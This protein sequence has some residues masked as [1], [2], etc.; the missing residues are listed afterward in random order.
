MK[1][2]SISITKAQL[3]SFSVSLNK[4]QPE[5]SATIGLFTDGGKKISDYTIRTNDWEESSTF[6]L[7][8]ELL[9]LIGDTMRIL[10]GVVVRHCRDGQLGL[11]APA[12]DDIALTEKPSEEIEDAPIDL[13]DI[14][15]GIKKATA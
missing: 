1:K 3:T 13:G 4:G 7:P 11:S 5:V 12:P 9:P 2:L 15:F 10:E 8:V 14:D 6:E